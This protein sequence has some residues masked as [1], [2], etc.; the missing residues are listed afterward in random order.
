M[1]CSPLQRSKIEDSPAGFGTCKE[2]TNSTEPLED[3]CPNS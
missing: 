3:A 2:P 1:E